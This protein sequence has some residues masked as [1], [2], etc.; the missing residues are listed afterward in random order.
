MLQLNNTGEAVRTL[1]TQLTKLGYKPGIIDGIFGKMTLASVVLFQVNHGLKQ[2]GIVGSI[3]QGAIDH[4][5]QTKNNSYLSLGVKSANVGV[6]QEKLNKLGFNCGAVDNV[7]GNMTRN[8]VIAFQRE[9]GLVCDGIVGTLTLNA[10]ESKS[11]VKLVQPT[12][13]SSGVRTKVVPFE[14]YLDQVPSINKFNFF[15]IHHEARPMAGLTPEGYE[16]RFHEINAEHIARGFACIGYNGVI[17]PNGT[18]IPGRPIGKMPAA[19]LG[20]N[21]QSINYCLIGNFMTETPTRDQLVTLYGLFNEAKK[22][23]ANIKAIGHKEAINYVSWAT[24]TDC[25][26]RLFPLADVKAQLK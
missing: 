9:K 20:L 21:D 17:F 11:G 4:D 8:A 18:F 10:L 15:G 22:L 24:A 16:Q 19:M 13:I 3:T 1:Q 14:N 23:N 12:P 25:P 26:G 7:F 6:I 5:L 2:D